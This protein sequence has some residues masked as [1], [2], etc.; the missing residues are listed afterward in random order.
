MIEQKLDDGSI[1]TGKLNL[2]D[3]AGSERVAKTNASGKQL[4]EVNAYC[5]IHY[6]AS[7]SSSFTNKK[8]N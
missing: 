6:G 5:C 2:V 3:L 4:D 1:K 7:L 8:K